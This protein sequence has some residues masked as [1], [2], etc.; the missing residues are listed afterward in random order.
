MFDHIPEIRFN[1]ILVIA[2]AVVAVFLFLPEREQPDS[3]AA[4]R[5]VSY[6]IYVHTDDNGCQYIS[7]SNGG[8]TPRMGVN[9]KQICS[10]NNNVIND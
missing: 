4:V 2:L 7:I 10:S 9:G 3:T 8:L 5:E 1:I 6:N